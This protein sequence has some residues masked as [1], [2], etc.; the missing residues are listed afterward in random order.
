MKPFIQIIQISIISIIFL[1]GCH[2]KTTPRK[3]DGN[4]EVQSGEGTIT[5]YYSFSSDILSTMQYDYNKPTVTEVKFDR[6]NET[7]SYNFDKKNGTYELKTTST[8]NREIQTDEYYNSNGI[9]AENS[10]N[11]KDYI[12]SIEVEKG[13]F[14]ITGGTGDIA[15]NSQIVLTKLTKYTDI[16]H[17]YSYY[18]MYY[19]PIT[20]LTEYCRKGSFNDVC[21][22]YHY[23]PFQTSEIVKMTN[24]HLDQSLI[25]NVKSIKKDELVIYVE[26]S[27]ITEPID[28]PLDYGTISTLSKINYTLKRK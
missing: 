17:E 16:T 5:N 8:K 20:D 1:T 22:C 28:D 19:I 10:I 14:T 23:I 13:T 7:I 6:S 15:K 26:N 2:K 18:D 4:W 3:L 11:I 25:L 9:K 24:S 21:G 27:K 12:T